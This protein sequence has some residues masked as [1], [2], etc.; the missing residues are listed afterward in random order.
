MFPVSSAPAWMR[1]LM[2]VDPLTYGVDG[3]RI[4]VLSAATP[5]AA[6]EPS[7]AEAARASGL[8]R[9]DL[10]FD[11]A[12]MAVISAAITALA[13]ARFNRASEV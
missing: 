8:V 13:A 12:I 4:I 2:S 7:L 11:I 1:V 10:G 3:L 9:W 6:S 5:S